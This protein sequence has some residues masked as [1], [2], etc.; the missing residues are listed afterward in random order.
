MVLYLHFFVGLTGTS[1]ILQQMVGLMGTS[2]ML[3]QMD[4]SENDAKRGTCTAV[5][6]I[7]K[8]HILDYK[9]LLSFNGNHNNFIFRRKVT[10]T[11]NNSY[12]K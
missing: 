7:S 11:D 3:Q 2:D 5:M 1:A 12:F 10:A 4:K 6:K 9:F 8:I